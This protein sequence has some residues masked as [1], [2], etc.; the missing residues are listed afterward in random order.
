M[1]PTGDSNSTHNES[2]KLEAILFFISG[3]GSTIAWTGIL[4]NLVFYTEHLGAASYIY[5]NLA[6]YIPLLPISLAQA[7][8][9]SLFDRKYS[10]L[11]TFLF[12][13]SI[14]YGLAVVAVFFTP[15]ARNSLLYTIFLT[16]VLGTTSA[17]LQGALKQM[18][19]FV[20]KDSGL[21]QAAVSSGMQGSSIAVLIVALFSGFGDSGDTQG[22]LPFNYTMLGA[23]VFCWSMFHWLVTRSTD[24][25]KSMRRRD[26][27]I[28]DSIFQ[29][30]SSSGMGSSNNATSPLLD[31]YT[32]NASDA[33]MDYWTLTKKT[34]VHCISLILTLLASM[35]VGAYLN[36][37]PSADPDN[38]EFAQVLFYAKM[39]P[40]V[41]GRPFT[42]LM[43][44]RSEG[45]VL[46]VTIL[47]LLYLPIFLIYTLTDIIPR[48]DFWITLGLAVFS[49]FSGYIV[50]ATYQ[51]APDNLS[52]VEKSN[53]LKQANLLNICFSSSVLGGL[54]IG[55]ILLLCLGED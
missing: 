46:T 21:L 2:G 27:I 55:L 13:G 15:K 5:L 50:T 17:V 24:V 49:F 48:S 10:S 7:R 34:H 3:I 8:W 23:T 12:R 9:D 16:L 26:S 14:S 28:T 36:R 19:A 18:A 1:I 44:P 33:E 35:L 42:I 25:M 32:P 41:L 38:V 51:L 39:I 53:T 43:K 47:R 40:D 52:E 45:F 4:S 54:L 6:V 31:E 11:N 22:F 29:K 20:Y 30:R 37:V